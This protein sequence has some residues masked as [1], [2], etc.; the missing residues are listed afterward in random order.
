[1]YDEAVAMAHFCLKRRWRFV[2]SGCDM[3][4]HCTLCEEKDLTP[5]VPSG[6]TRSYFHCAHCDLIF[7]DQRFH[8][9]RAAERDR[10]A[11]HCNGIQDTG[12]VDFLSR[13]I[14][15]CVPFLNKQMVGLDYGCGPTPTL[16]RMLA[17]L[18]FVC[19]DYDPLFGYFPAAETYDFIFATECFEH[20]FWPGNE[21]RSIDRLLKPGGYLGIMTERWN[22]L[23]GF[24][25]WYYK[26]DRTHVSFYH[27]RTFSWIT[28][29]FG[30]EVR[31]SD[32]ERVVVLRK[33][34]GVR[35]VIEV[36][37]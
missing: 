28:R 3:V 2:V 5:V 18:G 1:M 29:Q 16:S 25:T 31:Y 35:E 20:F 9:S 33:G 6:D 24:K 21:L 12:Y 37:R 26:R 15:P 14:T 32:D 7:V 17:D 8:L 22:T 10:Y 11:L 19:D 13:V 34:G 23:D 4:D 27:A 30:Y 36:N